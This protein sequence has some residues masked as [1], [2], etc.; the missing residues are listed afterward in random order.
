MRHSLGIYRNPGG[1]AEDPRG[2][3]GRQKG[4][5]CGSG[6]QARPRPV[7]LVVFHGREL[8]SQ[9]GQEDFE[10]D[11]WETDGYGSETSYLIVV[12]IPANSCL[13]LPCRLI[14]CVFA[15]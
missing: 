6:E 3:H 9:G 5:G 8:K 13:Y 10:I 1:S 14:S 7:R 12:P 15:F 2:S 11:H 4:D